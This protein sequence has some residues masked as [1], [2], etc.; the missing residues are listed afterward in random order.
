M[1]RGT[2]FSVKRAEQPHGPG[3]VV[4]QTGGFGVGV[5][6]EDVGFTHPSACYCLALGSFFLDNVRTNFFGCFKRS[7]PKLLIIGL[8]LKT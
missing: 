7:E 3:V 6:L 2:I 1:V 4:K 5:G 8:L